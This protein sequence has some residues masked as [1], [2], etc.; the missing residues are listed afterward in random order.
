[1]NW[2]TNDDSENTVYA[3]DVWKPFSR[4]TCLRAMT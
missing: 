4:V 3:A 1:M 2:L